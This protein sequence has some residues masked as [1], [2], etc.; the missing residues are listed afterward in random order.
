MK[1]TTHLVILLLLSSYYTFSQ[2]DTI[3]TDQLDSNEPTM[4]RFSNYETGIATKTN[5]FPIHLESDK[6]IVGVSFNRTSAFVFNATSNDESRMHVGN[7]TKNSSNQLTYTTSSHT[8]L[9]KD[10]RTKFRYYKNAGNY[11]VEFILGTNLHNYFC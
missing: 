8:I 1:K 10:N 6:N 4:A 11:F 3:T 9:V 7:A 5:V 2:A